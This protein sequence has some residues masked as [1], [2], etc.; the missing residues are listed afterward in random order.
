MHKLTPI[1]AERIHSYFTASPL[2]SED[3][4]GAFAD[5]KRRLISVLQAQID[6][7]DDLTIDDYCRVTGSTINEHGNES[8]LR[9][10]E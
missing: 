7:T 3:P 10:N 6:A 4:V 2:F 9:R 8:M 1:M 5:G